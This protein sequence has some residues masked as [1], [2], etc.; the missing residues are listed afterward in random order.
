MITV[1]SQKEA[2]LPLGV[3]SFLNVFVGG[4]S[5]ISPVSTS[6]EMGELPC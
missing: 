2:V 3:I 4:G 5:L 6:G 1:S